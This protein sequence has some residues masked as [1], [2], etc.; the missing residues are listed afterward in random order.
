MA[1][2]AR[3]ERIPPI[4]LETAQ[5]ARTALQSDDHV[6]LFMELGDALGEIFAP[7]EVVKL[8]C[9]ADDVAPHVLAIATIL[10]CLEGLSD[11]GVAET[12]RARAGWQYALR[13]GAGDALP[14]AAALRAFRVHLLEDRNAARAF[15]VLL[16]RLAASP[17]GRDLA[18]LPSSTAALVDAVQTVNLL[19]VALRGMRLA[20]NALL[21][22]RSADARGVFPAEWR[23]R[24]LSSP[25]WP[26]LPRELGARESFALAVAADGFV[27]LEAAQRAF[28]GSESGPPREVAAMRRTWE[29]LFEREGPYV[30][31]RGRPRLPGEEPQRRVTV[32]L[33]PHGRVA[34]HLIAVGG[35]RNGEAIRSGP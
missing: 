12:M 7:V 11:V 18:P 5:A 22:N 2:L 34:A 32:G 31:W 14:D 27:L 6:A 26:S 3:M 24:Y 21:A 8:A 10:Q 4:P 28:A 19:A 30:A 23:E 15:D 13:I 20:G 16:A 35:R 1:S 9:I 33:V 25:H 17:A 29:W